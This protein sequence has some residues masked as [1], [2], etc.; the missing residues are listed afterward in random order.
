MKK[1]I[2]KILFALIVVC[3]VLSLAGCAMQPGAFG[4][5][6]SLNSVMSDFASDVPVMTKTWGHSHGSTTTSCAG[7]SCQSETNS[8]GTSFSISAP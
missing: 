4:N 3:G 2:Q 5:A 1:V 6:A 7:N 8:S